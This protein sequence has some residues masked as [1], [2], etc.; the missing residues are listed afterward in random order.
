MHFR[1]IIASKGKACLYW[2]TFLEDVSKGFTFI[3]FSFTHQ[4]STSQSHSSFL[5]YPTVLPHHL[6]PESCPIKFQS[7]AFLISIII[8]VFMTLS[9]EFLLAIQIKFTSKTINEPITQ[10]LP[11]ADW[12]VTNVICLPIFFTQEFKGSMGRDHP[13]YRGKT[14]RLKIKWVKMM[15]IS[16]LFINSRSRKFSKFLKANQLHSTN[17][18]TLQ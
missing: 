11:P 15:K 4:P 10:A 1:C 18:G 7:T 5:S 6:L 13:H 17:L 16:T 8:M 3:F 2:L 9:S 12:W 14:M